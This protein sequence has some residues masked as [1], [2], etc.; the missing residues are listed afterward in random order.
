MLVAGQPP[1]TGSLI[2]FIISEPMP[3]SH[4]IAA[5]TFFKESAILSRLAEI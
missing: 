3:F 2:G 5:R 1:T 4:R